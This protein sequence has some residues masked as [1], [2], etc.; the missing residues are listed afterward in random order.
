MDEEKLKRKLKEIFNDDEMV[1]NLTIQ[2]QKE[3]LG[4]DGLSVIFVLDISECE[5]NQLCKLR[6]FL[7]TTD[8]V[9]CNW[10]GEWKDDNFIKIYCYDVNEEELKKKLKH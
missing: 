4:T 5:F 3:T 7:N 6:T 10:W 9:V 1:I 2:N 8:I